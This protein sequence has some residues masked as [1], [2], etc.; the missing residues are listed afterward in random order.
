MLGADVGHGGLIVSE[1]LHQDVLRRVLHAA[2]PIEP[3]AARFGPGCPGEIVSYLGPAVGIVWSDLELS[4]NKDHKAPYP[5][6]VVQTLARKDDVT[7]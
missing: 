5:E 6:Q 2:R 4:G 7:G 1:R 3:K